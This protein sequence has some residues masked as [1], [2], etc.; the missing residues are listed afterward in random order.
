MLST[1][2]LWLAAT[3]V[4]LGGVDKILGN[5]FGLADKFQEGLDKIGILVL[6]MVGIICLAPVL[7]SVIAP[8]ISPLCH[9]IGIDPAV[10]SSILACDMGGYQ[11]G[12]EL[13]EN[14]QIGLYAGIIVASMFGC[15]IVFIIPVGL[16]MIEPEDRPFFARGILIGMISVP[17]GSLIGGIVAGFEL[18]PLLV[19]TIPTLIISLLV[20]IGMK[21][22][23][24][25]MIKGCTVFGRIIEIISI[26]GLI[27]SAFTYLTG[28]T[29]L[30]GMD[31][32]MPAVTLVG[33]IGIVLM[34]MIP[35]FAIL[36]KILD[37]PLKAA[38][39]HIGLNEIS[40]GG[41]LLNLANIIYAF[42][43]IKDM[44]RRGKV[45]NIA[46][47]VPASC[48]FSG[49]LALC[50]SV[51]P[52]LI[53]PMVIGKLSGGVIALILGFLMTRD[54]AELISSVPTHDSQII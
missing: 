38:G 24:H 33:S 36:L 15:T 8:V 14:P 32:I 27:L 18:V 9:A 45:I 17:F 22:C 23:P 52:E 41:F 3:G 19:N 11:L 25:A 51:A 5:R 30:P 35:F 12:M 21:L 10:C 1:I 6:G 37:R 7:A 42:T 44:D 20:A 2:I 31:D 49:H 40:V 13:A 28:I 46:M 50:A 43:L 34:G 48:V 26:A 53:A 4:V 47:M 54:L 16:S 39:K 29:V